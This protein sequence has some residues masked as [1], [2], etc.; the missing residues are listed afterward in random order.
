MA[1]ITTKDSTTIFYQDWGAGQPIIFS[2]IDDVA[3][4]VHR[5]FVAIG[6]SVLFGRFDR[7]DQAVT[8]RS[9]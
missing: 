8:P 6:V 9:L 3:S 2:A 5:N 7:L 4:M 1:T